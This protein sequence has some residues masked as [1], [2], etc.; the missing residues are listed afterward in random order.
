[1]T[2]VRPDALPLAT[3]RVAGIGLVLGGIASTQFGAAVAASLFPRLGALGVVSLRL[4][5]AAAVLLIVCRPTLRGYRRSDWAVIFAFGVAMGGMNALFY[6][7]IDR[8][9]Q[10]AAVTFEVL[11]PLVLSVVA[12]RKATAWLWAALALAGVVLLGRG[13]F[14]QLNLPGVAFALGAA[15]MWAAYILLSARTGSRFPKV[16]GLALAMTVAAVLTL[17]LGVA[18]AGNALLDPGSLA[19]GLA[20]A[21]LSS[22]LPYTVEM[23][24]LRRLS[25]SSFAV[26]QSLAPAVAVVAGFLVLHQKLAFTEVVAIV[27][28]VIASAGAVYASRKPAPSVPGL[29]GRCRRTARVRAC[30][31][32]WPGWR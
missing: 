1:M 7:A 12:A 10:G 15:A 26:L 8:I 29:S 4:G 23:L 28:V 22:A 3:G 9:P 31:R 27:M 2:D 20:V 18:D 19:L 24:S 25:P 5:F 21:L 30:W 16:D 11:G 6:Q 13:G 32:P 14:D 17:P